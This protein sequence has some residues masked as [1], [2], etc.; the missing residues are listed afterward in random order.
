MRM[1]SSLVTMPRSPRALPIWRRSI[2][3]QMYGA[4][5]GRVGGS[6]LAT[7]IALLSRREPCTAGTHG[8]A[9]ARRPLALDTAI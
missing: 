7:R 8:I 4:G 6:V 1:M 3:Q 2:A 9:D 5:Q